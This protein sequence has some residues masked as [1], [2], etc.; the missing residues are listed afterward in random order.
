MGGYY[1]STSMTAV[2]K[3][4]YTNTSDNRMVGKDA[5]TVFVQKTF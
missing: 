5:V 3:A 2:Q 1:T 4:F